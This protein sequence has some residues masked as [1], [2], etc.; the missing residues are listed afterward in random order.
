MQSCE[1]RAAG[2]AMRHCHALRGLLCVLLLAA[3]AL[4][5]ASAGAD[6][7]Q[8]LPPFTHSAASEWLN[9]VPLDADALRG[10]PVLIEVWT[11]ECSN[12][13]ASLGWMQRI[14]TEYRPLG[15]VVVGVHSPELPQE[16]DAAQ[17]AAAVR[18]LGIRYPVMLDADYSYWRALGNHY[19]PAFYLYDAQG[20]LRSTRVGELHSGDAGAQAFERLIAA[21]LASPGAA[22][23]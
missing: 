16:R 22:R 2:A 20:R 5:A 19:W 13:L 18:R 8:E 21:Q 1:S 23:P 7:P 15:L 17:V 14:A 3:S 9:T 4:G 6:A 12:C 10:R 11:F